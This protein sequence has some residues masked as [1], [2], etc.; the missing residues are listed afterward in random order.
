MPVIC[1]ICEAKEAENSMIFVKLEMSKP[2]GQY[3]HQQRYLSSQQY[4]SFEDVICISRDICQ[5]RDV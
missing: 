2:L 1:S 3:L 4:L 5:A